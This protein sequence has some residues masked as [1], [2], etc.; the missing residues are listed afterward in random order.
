MTDKLG[1]QYTALLPPLTTADFEALATS[2]KAEG[3]VQVPI[4]VDEGNEILDG[5]H[6]YKIDPTCPRK[7][8]A[9]LDTPAQK[10][11]AAI[12]YNHARRNMTKEQREALRETCRLVALELAAEL[13]ADGGKRWSQE[14]IGAKLGFS[15]ETVSRW[16]AVDSVSVMHVH[17]TNIAAARKARTR[18]DW[19]DRRAIW[20]RAQQG[21]THAQIAADYGVVRSR[22]TQI[23]HGYQTVVDAEAKAEAEADAR[24]VQQGEHVLVGDMRE[25]GAAI[26]DN[27]VDLIFTDPPYDRKSL[28]LYQDLGAFA[29]RVLIPGGS[30]ICYTGHYALIELLPTL[31]NHL[32]Y[33]WLIALT[34]SHGN[35]TF[36]GKFV[37]VGWKPLAW[38]TKGTR[39][40]K[41]IVRDCITGGAMGGYNPTNKAV[42][43]DW[44]QGEREAA[45]YVENLARRKGLV[46]DPFVGGGTTGA[47]AV[48]LGR[49]FV[50]IEINEKHARKAAGRIAA[51]AG[52]TRHQYRSIP[53]RPE[54]RAWPKITTQPPEIVGDVLRPLVY[55][56]RRK[57]LAAFRRFPHA[58]AGA[59]P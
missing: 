32:R 1:T 44:A 53:A 56:T 57:I 29:A 46:V 7:M 24:S 10:K 59:V 39:A 52:I 11:A 49:R 21:M 54:G 18:I 43:H 19:D 9:G 47:A 14:D 22:V 28:G 12:L 6:R 50:G 40:T 36:P 15:Q 51:A 34:H 33:H 17:K 20:Q 37:H 38:F 58:A 5:A 26:A 55:P 13:G 45:Y 48:K 8:I 23:V 41:N 27:S 3:G 35:R 31:A 42:Y 30:L 16:M 25:V 2:I 4:L